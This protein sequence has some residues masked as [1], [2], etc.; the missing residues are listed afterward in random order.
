MTTIGEGNVLPASSFEVDGCGCHLLPGRSPVMDDGI[1]QGVFQVVFCDSH[2]H[3]VEEAAYD[4]GVAV[5][6]RYARLFN[7]Q[8]YLSIPQV[9][10]AANRRMNDARR[11]AFRQEHPEAMQHEA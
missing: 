4:H 8:C 7:G 2:R 6:Q 11:I 5:M 1:K 9:G 10:C 3:L